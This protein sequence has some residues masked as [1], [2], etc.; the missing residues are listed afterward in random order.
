M[1]NSAKGIVSQ[2]PFKSNNIGKTIIPII[3]NTKVLKTEISAEILPFEKAV[4]IEEVKILIPIGK[5]LKENSLNP[6]KVM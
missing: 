4:N 6:D 1:I 5:K 2:I 3:T